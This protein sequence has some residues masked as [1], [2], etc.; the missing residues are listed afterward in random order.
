M[1]YLLKQHTIFFVKVGQNYCYILHMCIVHVI[2]A[3]DYIKDL[4]FKRP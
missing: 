1:F 2:F 4:E 3:L